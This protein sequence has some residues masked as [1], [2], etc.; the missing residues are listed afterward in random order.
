MLSLL[1]YG[2]ILL[3]LSIFLSISSH[4]M[5][6]QCV[7]NLDWYLFVTDPTLIMIDR[8]NVISQ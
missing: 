3:T 1:I 7:K 8:L 2:I 4:V 6:M 5:L